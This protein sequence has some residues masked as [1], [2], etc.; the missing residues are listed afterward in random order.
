VLI[1]IAAVLVVGF[2]V[3]MMTFTVRFT[4]RAVKTT[5]GQADEGDVITDPGL[6]FR[7][8]LAN[9]V[10][11]YDTRARYI[12]ARLEQQQTRDN[13][14]IIV[15]SFL[16]WRIADPLLFYQRIGRAAGDTAR[17]HYEEAD[18]LLQTQLRSGLSAVSKYELSELLTTDPAG[19]RL[20]ELE[21]DVLGRLTSPGEGGGASLGDY[22]IEVQFVGI[23]R[24]ELPEQT[25]EQVFERMR[26]TRER[27]AASAE[28]EGQAEADK[29]RAEAQS[30]AQRIRDFA[31]LYAAEIRARG[32]R[33]AAQYFAQLREEP[34]LAVFLENVEFIRDGLGKRATLVLPTDMPGMMLFSADAFLRASRGEVPAPFPVAD[35]GEQGSEAG[36]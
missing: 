4:E 28:S 33:E 12:E 10:T 30:A 26:K 35:T 32:D 20:A 21:R 23:N 7:V 27:L 11:V 1:P 3:Y 15:E 25:T 29:I 22:G 19:S 36:R 6:K 16:T 24:I 34:E 5:F 2:L 31:E 13:R 18:D 14:Q 8:P 17:Q 9:D